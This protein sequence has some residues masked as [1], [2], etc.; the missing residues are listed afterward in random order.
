MRSSRRRYRGPSPISTFKSAATQKSILLSSGLTSS[1]IDGYLPAVTSK[2]GEFEYNLW[3]NATAW[4]VVGE[5]LSP[6]TINGLVD[7]LSNPFPK[8]DQIRRYAE[9]RGYGAEREEPTHNKRH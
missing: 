1:H 8:P 3:M 2:T 7:A 5:A 6:G 9:L 4:R